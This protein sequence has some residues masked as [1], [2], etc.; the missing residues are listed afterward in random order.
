M[1]NAALHYRPTPALVAPEYRSQYEQGMRALVEESGA[2]RAT[3]KGRLTRAPC[4]CPTAI[5]FA[6]SKCASASPTA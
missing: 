6:R 2:E 3:A 4:G 5:A 1:P